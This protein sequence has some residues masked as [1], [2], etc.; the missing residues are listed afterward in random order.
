MDIKTAISKRVF[1]PLIY[2][3]LLN[4]IPSS[5]AMMDTMTLN[6]IQ[7]DKPRLSPSL[8]EN[9]DDLDLLGLNIDGTN[10]YGDEIKNMFLSNA[11]PFKKSISIAPLKQPNSEEYIDNN[12]DK[13]KELAI[14]SALT[15]SW[16]YTGPN[17][18][19]IEFTPSETDTFC[20]LSE[21]GKS[22]PYKIK[23]SG[24]LSLT[25]KT[26]NPDYNEYP[27]ELIT[28]QPSKVYTLS[29]EVSI[30]YAKPELKPTQAAG[31][32][33][34]QWNKDKGFLVQSTSDATKNFPTTAFYGAKFDI[35]LSKTNIANDFNWTLTKGSELVSLSNDG[36]TI[37]VLFNTPTALKSKDA[38][39]Y[40]I[41]SGTGYTVIIEGVHKTKGYKITYPFTI[42]KWFTSFDKMQTGTTKASSGSALDVVNGCLGLEG[43]Y[44]ISTARDLSN[45][46]FG[47]AAGTANFT[48]EIGTILGE[49]G[50]AS[51]LTYPNSWA[52]ATSQGNTFK[53]IWVYDTDRN[54]Y[55]D[56][57]TYNAKYHC[58][59]EAGKKNGLCTSVSSR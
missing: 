11:Y 2:I 47:T 3:L 50:D 40:V 25:S 59:N 22:G 38:W 51:Q 54:D 18:Q 48:R 24:D 21:K 28:E 23:L 6:T 44:Q 32:S 5:Y 41:G 42:T 17:N 16:Y 19:L 30:C 34:H 46:P 27:N 35:M 52:A 8:E 55:C 43:T 12:S 13:L 31:A 33:E 4:F 15:V 58:I 26:G 37:T 1:A 56:I 20:S 36:N 39:D 49:W 9:I 10:Y 53:R 14:K 57:H 45:A 29:D 7:G